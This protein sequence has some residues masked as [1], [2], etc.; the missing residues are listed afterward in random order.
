M[1]SQSDL[2]LGATVVAW[3]RDGRACDMVENRG[4]PGAIIERRSN[5]VKSKRLAVIPEAAVIIDEVAVAL[6]VT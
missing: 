4:R 3:S 5:W 1:T 2:Y 6:G